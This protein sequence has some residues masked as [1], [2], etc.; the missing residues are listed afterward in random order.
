[1]ALL[2]VDVEG[3][4]LEVLHGIAPQDWQ[5]IDQVAMEVENSVLEGEVT[6][7]LRQHGFYVRSWKSEDMAKLLPTSQV[8]QLIAKRI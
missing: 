1:M 2:K 3:A 4:E 8:V 7:L 5:R 6:A